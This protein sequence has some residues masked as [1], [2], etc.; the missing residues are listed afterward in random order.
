MDDRRASH[1]SISIVVV[2]VSDR[3]L[4]YNARFEYS[5]NAPAV[6]NGFDQL[7]EEV[8]SATSIVHEL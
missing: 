1:K 8:S 3:Y 4:L 5:K 2:D 6:F 7:R